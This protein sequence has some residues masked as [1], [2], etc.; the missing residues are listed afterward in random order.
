MTFSFA[1]REK[2]VIAKLIELSEKTVEVTTILKVFFECFFSN[3]CKRFSDAFDQ[4]KQVEREADEIR[5]NIIAETYKGLF[6]PDMREIIHSLTEGIDR[7]VNKC[8]SVS[9]ILNYQKPYVPEQIREE[10]I[11]QIDFG[12]RAAQSFTT[13]VRKSF[14]NIDEVHQYVLEVENHEHDEDMV[15]GA[16]LKEIFSLDLPLAEKL[17]LKE[18]VINIGD[19]VDRTE[20]ASDILEVLLLKLSY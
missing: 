3:E 18:L 6:L 4:V 11:S 17:Q 5:R 12:I 16:I 13:A 20:D 1:R 19:I 7:V 2:E 8:E 15:E 10:M 14:D 9:K